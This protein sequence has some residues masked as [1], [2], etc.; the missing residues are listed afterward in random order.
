VVGNFC[1]KLRLA[2]K[3]FIKHLT[4]CCLSATRLRC[5]YKLLLHKIIVTKFRLFI[6]ISAYKLPA[7]QEEFESIIHITAY[8][9]NGAA[10]LAKRC[11][12]P[13]CEGTPGQMGVGELP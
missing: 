13:F 2:T 1:S 6:F 5:F 11:E 7:A 10:D 9:G 4:P 8:V 3:P 12:P